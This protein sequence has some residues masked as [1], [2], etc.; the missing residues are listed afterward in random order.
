MLFSLVLMANGCSL[1]FPTGEASGRGGGAAARNALPD[2]T[3]ELL[4]GSGESAASAAARKEMDAFH[5]FLMGQVLVQDEQWLQ[6]EQAF[7]KAAKADPQGKE[8]RIWVINLAF[9]RGD[10]KKSV[11]Y[12]R[13]VLA[14]D[15]NLAS[16]RLILASILMALKEDAEAA[17]HFE[18]LLKSDADNMQVRLQLSQL[19]GRMKQPEKVREV[20]SPLLNNPEQAWKGQL[21]LGRAIAG[22]GDVE[23]SIE[24]FRKAMEMAPD[25]L[26]PVLALGGIHQVLG[27]DAEAENVFR[28]Y[29]A[30]HPE[31]ERMHSRLGKLLLK[32]ENVS[33]ALEEFRTLSRLFPSNVQPRLNAFVI[34]YNQEKFEEALQEL[35]LAEAVE[36]DNPGIRFFIGQTLAVM[37]R[38]EEAAK[39]FIDVPESSPYF[40]DAQFRLAFIEG[41][42]KDF[43]SAIKRLQ[44]L[45]QMEAGRVEY[46]LL[47]NN[48]QLQTEDFPGVLESS[49]AGLAAD[50][51]K[52]QFRF[53]RAMALEKLN[54]WPEA[55]QDLMEYLKRNPADPT[56]LNFLGY[57]WADRGINLEAA[58]TML[59]K[60]LELSPGD[61]FITDSV[62]WVLFR[63]HRLEESLGY[64]REAVRLLPNDAVVVEHLG[65]VLQALGH[66]EEA[67]SVWEKSLQLKGDNEALRRKLQETAP[68]GNKP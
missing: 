19:Y 65:D 35:R 55:E 11:L 36:T 40:K 68:A 66:T 34:L 9:Q 17:S 59:K 33:G 38:S 46:L 3:E 39:A 5:N 63:L 31:D 42:R 27:R 12:A 54:R 48:Y 52:D 56:V 32:M 58:L 44:Q 15:P 10:L 21:A 7:E 61:G 4:I 24:Y 2:G 6:A 16:I 29:L 64:M 53:N 57:S 28:T 67:R 47:L 49:A 37:G 62:G 1:P 22:G 26:E 25:Q 13:E 43:P 51:Q 30:S 45:L 23:G 41:S 60:A 14:I 20:L 8:S 18:T 50:G